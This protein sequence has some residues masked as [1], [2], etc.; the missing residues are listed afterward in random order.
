MKLKRLVLTACAA[1][2][3]ASMF[4]VPAKR[5]LRT[6][7]Q[8]DGTSI[9]LQLVGD[10][11]FHT[12]V[13]TDGL[14]VSRG[15][16]G[17]FYYTTAS[18]ISSVKA[19]NVGS[20][21]DAEL[22][23]VAKNADMLAP[24]SLAAAPAVK[25]RRSARRQLP[26][27]VSQVPNTGSPSVP[28]LLVEYKD[29]H[30]K[31]SDPLTTFETFFE[32]GPKS[33]RQYFVDQSNGKYTPNFDVYG[34]VRL[35][36]NREVYG[37]ND[38]YGNDKGV[39]AMVGEACLALDG[40]VDFSKYDN[41]GDGE[42]DVVIVIYA[43]DGEASSYEPDCEDAVWPCQWQLSSSDYGRA[44]NLDNTRVNKF[45]VFNEL[46]G[47]DITK[48]DGIGTFCH[49]FSH[50][51]DLPDFY[52]TNYGP[53]FGMAHWSLLDYG[54][55]ND[56][57]YTPIG[58]SGYE[59]AFMGWLELEEAQ[60]N[61]HYT[62]DPL[63]T[64]EPGKDRVIKVTNDADPDEYYLIENRKKQGWDAYL[65]TEG[66]MIY[67]VTYD[68]TAWATNTVNDYDL[69]RMT[70]IPADNNLKL[71]KTPFGYEVDE[72]NLLGDLWPYNGVANLTDTSTPSAR[73][74]TGSFMGKPI[75]GITRNADGTIS[76][77]AMKGRRVPVATPDFTGHTVENNSDLTLNWGT[78]DDND[79]TYTIEIREHSDI[80]YEKVISTTFNTMAHGWTSSGYT[81]IDQTEGAIRLA[82][83]SKAGAVTSRAFQSDASG[84]VT[85]LFNAK[86]YN[87]DK[88]TVA[89]SLLSD[90]GL[91]VKSGTVDLTS[92]YTNYAV[93]LNGEPNTIYTVKIETKTA[94][95]RFF[96]KWADIY[97]GDATSI[98]D[99]PRGA[100]AKAPTETGNETFRSV[101]G[102]NG[103]SHKIT[104][105]KANGIFD[106]RIKAE[107]VNA[108]AYDMSAWSKYYTVDLSKNGSVGI[109]EITVGDSSAPVEYYNLQGQRV[110]AAN[111][112]PGIY[113]RRQGDKSVKVRF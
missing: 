29:I 105:L 24:G 6:V 73:V 7:T 55:Y 85:V 111:L 68:R 70:P 27:R 39:G 103:T 110:N 95:K 54:C 93:L 9:S 44:L 34:P 14:A 5:G 35:T 66:L 30:F 23:F 86:N 71:N 81:E 113:I 22:Q 63:N 79:V 13:T 41:D 59:K 32:D 109:F 12:Y 106:C 67:H 31:D 107:P 84:N 104:G 89:V 40:S 80:N 51:L 48:I 78:A 37:G 42:C 20:R 53:H 82:S 96:M 58:Y 101:S 45:A 15:D 83:A 87:T 56:N 33:A 52:D 26:Q 36:K 16:D 49:E 21:S 50:C 74:N 64:K 100:S 11:Y 10:E 102:I 25:T 62:L 8:P 57:G 28:V 65:P 76:F 38:D 99:D 72:D 90:A 43:H 46:N 1:L 92:D 75:N 2:V 18:G 69:Q 108:D 77:W 112:T 88:T 91:S 4:A 17:C 60:P 97:T 98:K 3:T 94:K 19:H 47:D 61:T